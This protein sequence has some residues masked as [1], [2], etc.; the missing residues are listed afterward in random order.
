MLSFKPTD[1]MTLV[2]AISKARNSVE[3]FPLP[4]PP[5]SSINQYTNE[6]QFP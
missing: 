3:F 5:L 4:F 1:G 2:D 6:Y